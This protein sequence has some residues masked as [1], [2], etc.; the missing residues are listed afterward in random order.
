MMGISTPA[1][2]QIT[3]R[4]M[5]FIDGENLS[6]RFNDYIKDK[7]K[8]NLPLHVKRE[9]DIY[10][11][12]NH[13]IRKQH[14][15]C[16]FM[17][18]FY[19]TSLTGDTDKLT[20]VENTLIDLGIT[21]PRVFKKEKGGRTKQVDIT[22]ATEMLSNC[23]NNNYDV[24]VLVAGDKDYVPLVKELKRNGKNISLWFIDNGLNPE[25][26]READT[27]FDMTNVFLE[28]DKNKIRLARLTPLE[29]GIEDGNK[30]YM[31]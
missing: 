13:A 18:S 22:L 11:W 10:I 3:S 12:S 17:R 21:D 25:L 26:K 30:P 4:F 1:P 20:C 24:A 2:T 29:V 23:Y 19:Y 27:F 16:L 14:G 6:I 15:G 9:K 5:V 8:S 7:A 31:L 28:E